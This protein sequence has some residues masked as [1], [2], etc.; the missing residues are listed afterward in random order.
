MDEPLA[1]PLLADA[2]D[3]P[4]HPPNALVAT[5][6]LLDA[7]PAPAPVALTLLDQDHLDAQAAGAGRALGAEDVNVGANLID[8]TH[9][10][11]LEVDVELELDEDDPHGHAHSIA[12][13]SGADWPLNWPTQEGCTF[14]TCSTRPKWLFHCF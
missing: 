5:L 7:D 4:N 2:A 3:A 13:H 14:A 8:Q 6:T 9:D 11:V 12:M 1:E 10:L